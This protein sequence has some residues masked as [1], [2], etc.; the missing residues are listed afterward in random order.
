MIEEIVITE[1]KPEVI[2]TNTENQEEEPVLVVQPIKEKI[3]LK[4]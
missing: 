3:N 1:V 4:D 2:V